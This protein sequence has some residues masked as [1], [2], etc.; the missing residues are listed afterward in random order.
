MSSSSFSPNFPK[1]DL[2]R[3]IDPDLLE[4]LGDQLL[5][6]AVWALEVLDPRGHCKGLD[7]VPAKIEL[8]KKD[9]KRKETCADGGHSKES[10][11]E[12]KVL[13]SHVPPDTK[14]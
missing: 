9:L 2:L 4:D 5:V 10:E 11:A 14:I 8:V 12:A 13:H 7:T 3:H 1:I 6:V